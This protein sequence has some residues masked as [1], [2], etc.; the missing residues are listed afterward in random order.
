[1]DVRVVDAAGLGEGW[2]ERERNG[3]KG[4]G[5]EGNDRT[6]DMSKVIEHVE[7]D[8]AEEVS[9]GNEDDGEEEMALYSLES[10]FRY[11]GCHAILFNRFHL[12][13][14]PVLPRVG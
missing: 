8:K 3:G 1:M 11:D 12:D 4:G 6:Y 2:Y 10:L 13:R 5:E 7:R 9:G 14:L